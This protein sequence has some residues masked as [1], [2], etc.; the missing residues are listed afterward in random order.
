MHPET[1]RSSIR[2]IRRTAFTLVEVMIVLIVIC[3]MIA[4]SSPSFRRSVEQS[5]AD[6]A[7][8]NLK[9]VWSAERVYW[10]DQHA[11]A[12][13]D[14]LNTAKLL[15]PEVLA[16]LTSSTAMGGYV[17]TLNLAA[18]LKTFTAK[19]ERT[20]GSNSFTIDQDGTVTVSGSV[21]PGF[22]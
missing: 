3:A 14:Q 22:Q 2:R 5:R 12:T 7:L 17:Y 6:I 18:D 9:A 16:S 19:A 1:I 20:V 11:Y 8:A 10:L 13:T 21:T 4:M 15:D